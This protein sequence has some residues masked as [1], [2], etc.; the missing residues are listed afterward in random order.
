MA[1][2]LSIAPLLTPAWRPQ[3]RLIGSAVTRSRCASQPG[4]HATPGR[5]GRVTVD[6]MFAASVTAD[7][8]SRLQ[9]LSVPHQTAP[10]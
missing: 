4:P 7:A 10:P 3:D 1:G 8:A 2:A 9:S 5:T 6:S